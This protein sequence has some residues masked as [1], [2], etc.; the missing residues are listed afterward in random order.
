MASAECAAI[1]LGN[2]DGR[3]DAV[4]EAQDRDVGLGEGC[5]GGCE[6]FLESG[7]VDVAKEVVRVGA[8]ED[9]DFWRWG[10]AVR[11][12]DG[13]KEGEEV[14]EER[15]V[16]EVDGWVVECHAS[17]ITGGLDEKSLVSSRSVDYSLGG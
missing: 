13:G 3:G 4:E 16:N 11:G 2:E 6:G 1:D 8:V 5:F 10:R 17:H 12:L 7:D 9:D 15:C 14:G